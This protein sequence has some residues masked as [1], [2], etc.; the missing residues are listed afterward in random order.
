MHMA[1]TKDEFESSYAVRAGLL[2]PHLK[3]LGLEA[4]PCTCG[5]PT[6]QGWQMISLTAIKQC[7]R[8][9]FVDDNLNPYED[10]NKC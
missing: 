3:L 4:V 9:M 2:V 1:K 6:C 7:R 8:V 5:L 10:R